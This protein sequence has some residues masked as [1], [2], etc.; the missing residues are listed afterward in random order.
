[1]CV[2]DKIHVLIH[3]IIHLLYKLKAPMFK[4]ILTHASINHIPTHISTPWDIHM[5]PGTLHWGEG[6]YPLGFIEDKLL[7]IEP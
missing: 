1:M 4:H 5:Y 2:C 3:K 6:G 7:I